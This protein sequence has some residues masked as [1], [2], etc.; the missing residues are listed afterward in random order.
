MKAE[1]VPS[2]ATE[3]ERAMVETAPPGYGSMHSQE[4]IG[5]DRAVARDG[6]DDAA[7]FYR[8]HGFEAGFFR[9]WRATSPSI[10]LLN[11]T[12]HRFATSAGASAAVDRLLG[13]MGLEGVQWVEYEP[14]GVPNAIG[15]E[16]TLPGGIG[17]F[18][19]FTK[20]RD[21]VLV[22]AVS[23]VQSSPRQT[24]EAVA[25]EQYHRL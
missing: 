20:G 2:W 17:T 4:A 23:R 13:Q 22:F 10:N 24:A 12:I 19:L 5:F 6:G 9:E 18:V 8:T 7:D 21:Y 25:R 15:R 11:N 14:E 1:P 16:K 3:L